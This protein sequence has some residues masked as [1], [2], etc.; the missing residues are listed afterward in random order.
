M[1]HLALLSTL[2][3]GACTYFWPPKQP[4]LILSGTVECHTIAVGSRIGGRVTEVLVSEGDRVQKNQIL[5]RFD[6]Y[7]LLALQE[8]AQAMINQVQAELVR[9]RTGFQRE[10]IEEVRSAAEA[11]RAQLDLV[12]HGPRKQEIERAQAELRAAK[13][14]LETAATRLERQ[15]ELRKEGVVFQQRLDDLREQW[16]VSEARLEATQQELELLLSGSRPEEIEAAEKKFAEWMARLRRLEKGSRP[17]DIA[18]AEARLRGAEA[19]LHA[20]EIRLSESE[21]TAPADA[22]VEII[23]IRPGDLIAPGAPVAT[24]LEKDQ[25]YIEV[26]L[27]ETKLG[28]VQLGDPVTVTVDSFPGE[29]LDGRVTFIAQEGEFTPR[30]VQTRTER[31]HLVFALRVRVN[32]SHRLRPG[33]AADACLQRITK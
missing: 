8:Q 7:D 12:R 1:V 11:A 18:A 19:E 3:G 33:M 17:E 24:L 23:E 32:D 30:N 21:V 29:S 10:E 27:P 13:I 5:V 25:I 9:L 15:A 22:R 4:C 20:V 28:L 6:R 31:E 26:Y 2:G 14:R 16:Q